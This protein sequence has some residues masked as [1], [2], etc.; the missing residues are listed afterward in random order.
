M[1]SRPISFTAA[2][3]SS[4]VAELGPIDLVISGRD[5]APCLCESAALS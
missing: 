2:F 1:R 5:G 3:G 4:I